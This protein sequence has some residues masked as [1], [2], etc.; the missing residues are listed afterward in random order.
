MHCRIPR[1]ALA[2][3]LASSLATQACKSK[4]N[5]TE[6]RTRQE[7]F[8]LAS[9]PAAS[10]PVV[11]D[12]SRMNREVAADEPMAG[13]ALD[14]KEQA[15]A[16]SRNQSGLQAEKKGSRANQ[17]EGITRAWFP[18]TF[19]F[20]PLIITDDSGAATVTARVPDRL[21]SWRILALAH[22]RSGAQAGTVAS[23]LGTLP[24]YVDPIVPKTLVI[25]DDVRIPIQIVNTTSNP[26]TT[27]LAIEASDAI[28][29]IATTSLTLAGNSSRVEYARLRVA[30]AGAATLRVT[31]GDT[32]AVVRTIAVVPSG[33]PVVTTRSG[34]LAAPRT[35]T[36][37]GIAGAD[38]ST[39]RVQLLAFPG[40][41]AL[42]RSELAVVTSRSSLA[43]D[44]Y[45]LLLAGRATEMLTAL[46][47]QADPEAIRELSILASQRAIRH[48]RTLDIASATLL[49]EAALAHV[50]NPVLQRLG[51]RAADYLVS[52]QLPDGTF[53]LGSGWTV[54]RVLVATAEATRAIA[55]AAATPADRKRATAALVRAAGA[56][57]RNAIHI[58]DGYTAAAILASGAVT[59]ALAETLRSRVRA[60][61]KVGD[62]GAKVLEVAPEIVRFDG[63]PPSQLEATAM[64]VLAL[65]GDAKA[66]LADL[67]ATVLG[68]YGF[69]RGWGDGR[70]NLVA[71]RAVL[72]LFKDPL[73]PDV[74]IELLMD[75]KLITSGVLAKGKLREVLVLGAE[76][77]GLSSAH[78]W[79]VIA[80]P[81]VPGLGFSLELRS[82]VPWQPSAA[83]GGLELQLAPKITAIV[84]KPTTIDVVAIAPA[85]TPLHLQHAL[86]AGVQADM[87]SLQALV[88]S[89]QV[90]RFSVADGS[91]D[92]YVPAL[93]AGRSFTASY[94]VIATLAG[95]LHTT[96]SMIEAQGNRFTVP[97]TTWTIK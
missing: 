63:A 35:L 9:P 58:E 7:P 88:D 19:L 54:Q 38:P 13:E 77:P 11:A 29:T 73:P 8:A 55:S 97:P 66:P 70:T 74:Q 76:A 72:V 17:P 71:M 12:K 51:S 40:A 65:Q 68:G 57:E 1:H 16:D 61:I 2:M 39:D 82:W 42:L 67:G 87:A 18:E 78:Q 15:P 6:E 45:A 92:L 36:I 96:A 33:R 94:R 44:A 62:D 27:T 49:T 24:V 48:A 46:G 5:A 26:V 53:A 20:E 50:Q 69:L 47:G 14:G 28:A 32:D 64:A 52:H 79:S 90:E 34:T 75:G 86:P 95:T 23:F 81:P 21:T 59:G 3:F 60:S 41:L 25:G 31:L 89:G 85:G 91:I 43:D 56:F 10:A 4:S 37:A 93:V 83:Q 84:G 80:T 22:S 30:R